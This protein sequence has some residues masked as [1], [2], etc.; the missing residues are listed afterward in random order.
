MLIGGGVY[1]ETCVTP[2]RTALFG[3]GGRA[4]MVVAGLGGAVVLHTFHPEAL[5]DDVDANFNPAGIGVVV[6]SSPRRF[7]FE[8]LHPMARPRIIPLPA[9]HP[10]NVPLQGEEVLRFGCLEGDF[11]VAAARAV[12]DPQSGSD[13]APFGFNGSTAG[14]LAMILNANELRGMA[15]M[16]DLSH[17]ATDVMR[18]AAASVLVVKDGP[19]GAY[20]FEGTCLP[21]H[22]PAYPT[23]SVYKIGS[24]DVFSATFAHAWMSDRVQAAEAADR[25][26][27]RTAQYVETPAFP[28]PF[29]LP[30]R[31]A[32]RTDARGRRVLLACDTRTA[33]RRW[34]W[35]EAAR[36]L[37]DLGATVVPGDSYSPADWGLVAASVDKA[38][39]DIV[40]AHCD[41][42]RTAAAA[43]RAILTLG[44][45]VVVFADDPAA[46]EAA[47]KLG[48]PGSADLCSAL[49][50]TQWVPL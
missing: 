4:A 2:A 26:S 48:V 5:R 13:P 39:V 24:G 40:L 3:S 35:E 46:L 10:I 6:H 47:G 37:R 31:A 7:C 49:Y 17:A 19:A 9:G 16:D 33:S 34:V 28:L 27:R 8:Y 18:D 42:G 25:A 32:G 20:V 22:V 45:P 30:H 15:G 21:R 14:S 50:R 11:R 1:V 12:Y 29:E 44:K 43:L 23:D 36:G 38:A 41:D